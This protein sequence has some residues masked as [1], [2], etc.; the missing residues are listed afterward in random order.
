MDNKEDTK[1]ENKKEEGILD[2]GSGLDDYDILKS[3][4]QAGDED[5]KSEK[6]L[7]MATL[8]YSCSLL[9]IS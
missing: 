9:V 3:L 8:L 5:G 2:E 4:F 7:H 6:V 1:K